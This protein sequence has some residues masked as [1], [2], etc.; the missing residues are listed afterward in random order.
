[1]NAS[2]TTLR[3]FMILT[4]VFPWLDFAN[5]IIMLR[6]QTKVM[7]VSQGAN[8]LVTLLTLTVTILLT[9]GWNAV[10]GSLAQS[11]GV[12]SELIVVLYV[13]KITSS[14]KNRLNHRA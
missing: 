14:Q 5:G 3:V 13:L 4:F 6:G 7:V 1:M 8:V 10:I 2:L 12:L 11:L 9:P